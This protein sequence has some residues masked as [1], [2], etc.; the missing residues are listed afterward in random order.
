M[1]KIVTILVFASVFC[2]TSKVQAQVIPQ[3][4][5]YMFNGL[6]VNPAY[7]G[8]K[9]EFYAHLM[10]RQQWIGIDGAP[11]TIM[12][13]LDGD[14]GKGSNLGLVYAHDKVGAYR[15]NS[16]MAS[17]AYRFHVSEQGRLAFGLSAGAIYYGLDKTKVDEDPLLMQAQNLWRPQVDVGVY[18]DMPNFYAGL[19]VMSLISNASKDGPVQI[20]R[21]NPVPFL[22]VGGMVHFDEKWALA[23]SAL[24]KTD[25]KSPMSVDITAM[26]VYGETIWLGLSYRTGLNFTYAGKQFSPDA[27]HQTHALVVLAEIYLL[28]NLRLGAAYDFDLNHLSTDFTGGIE[29]S[30]GYYLQKRQTRYIT[31]RYF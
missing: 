24:L 12:L 2:S 4:S 14:F 25:F 19:S 27:L 11:Q 3:F 21:S 17:Y 31:P 29:V 16:I 23:P 26:G 18:F 30:L 6:Y 28:Q 9:E 7:A 15:T 20:M 22:T 13:G 5:Q 1:K 8:Y 10:Y